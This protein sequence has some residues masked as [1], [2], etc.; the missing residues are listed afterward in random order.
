MVNESI[1]AT[2]QLT[3]NHSSSLSTKT[4]K[5]AQRNKPTHSNNNPQSQDNF[6]ALTSMNNCFTMLHQ[7]IRGIRDKTSELIGSMLPMLP[8]IICLTEHNLKDQETESLSMPY[9]ALGAKFCRKKTK[10][11]RYMDFY[12]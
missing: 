9:Y 4:S 1:K 11:G 10:A 12:S 5:L 7:N 3:I 6:I 8:Q 2:N